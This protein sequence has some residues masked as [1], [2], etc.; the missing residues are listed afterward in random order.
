LNKITKNKEPSMYGIMQ[1]QDK[2]Y[3]YIKIIMYL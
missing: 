2:Y 1:L 3:T